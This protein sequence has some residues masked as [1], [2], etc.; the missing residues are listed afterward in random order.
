[1]TPHNAVDAR[2]WTAVKVP[3][4][5]KVWLKLKAHKTESTIAMK[6]LLNV[7]VFLSSCSP[8][9]MTGIAEAKNTYVV[10]A[11]ILNQ[12]HG[13]RHKFAVA[14]LW[15]SYKVVSGELTSLH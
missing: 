5:R 2:V 15:T 8:K 12:N 9:D 4:T 14:F 1:M 10:G 13:K 3:S 7:P 6:N 11:K